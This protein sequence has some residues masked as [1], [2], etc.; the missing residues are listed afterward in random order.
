MPE[1]EED[2]I[3]PPPPNMPRM[4]KFEAF[5]HGMLY[6]GAAQEAMRSAQQ[7]R[8]RYNETLLQDALLRRRQREEHKQRMELETQRQ[9]AEYERMSDALNNKNVTADDKAKAQAA[10]EAQKAT[11]KQA[12]NEKNRAAYMARIKETQAGREKIINTQENARFERS[13]D[14]LNSQNQ[15]TQDKI[16]AAA[17]LE[18]QRAGHAVDLQ[19]MRIGGQRDLM[20]EQQNRQDWRQ[21]QGLSAKYGPEVDEQGNEVHPVYQ[22]LAD[23][24]L[25]N[26]VT[27]EQDMAATAADPNIPEEVKSHL[28]EQMMARHQQSMQNYQTTIQR[29]RAYAQPMGGATQGVHRQK[30]QQSEPPESRKDFTERVLKMHAAMKGGDKTA[31]AIPIQKAV[32][33]IIELDKAY[34]ALRSGNPRNISGWPGRTQ[35]DARMMGGGSVDQ[36]A[37][38]GQQN[39]GDLNRNPGDVTST[40]DTVQGKPARQDQGELQNPANYSPVNPDP[41]TVLSAPQLSQFQQDQGRAEGTY[42]DPAQQPVPPIAQNLLGG[43]VNPQAVT[44]QAEM[45]KPDPQQPDFGQKIEQVRGDMVNMTR[46]P[47]ASQPTGTLPP[48]SAP[49]APPAQQVQQAGGGEFYSPNLNKK[50]TRAQ[51]EKAA[52]ARGM[53]IEQAVQQLGL[54]EIK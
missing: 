20:N 45:R 19:D 30:P 27:I 6:P 14:R 9:N 10:L 4:S 37:P 34:D 12:E 53:T 35:Q 28:I 22:A 42:V 49:A 41:S 38:V 8:A 17:D 24:H 31:D 44:P 26:A 13:A 7:E 43:G 47:V 11:F 3:P 36:T 15:L 39:L 23:Q 2:Y 51:I 40:L 54:M 50:Y 48:P 25:G 1:P 46:P 16:K 33:Q 18:Q 21:E 5:A 32:D 29:G 52:T